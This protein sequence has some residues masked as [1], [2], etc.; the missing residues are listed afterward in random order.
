M[1]L[2]ILH[3]TGQSHK[4][5]LSSPSANRAKVENPVLKARTHPEWL[6]FRRSHLHK[7]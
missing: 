7:M 6:H 5:E 4:K 3:F 2:S 1:L